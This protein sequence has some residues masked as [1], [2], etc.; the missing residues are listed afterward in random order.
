DLACTLSFE[1]AV[2]LCDAALRRTTHPVDAVP[3]TVLSRQDLLHELASVAHSYGVVK[4]REVI[5]F[6]DPL[7][8][9]P[10]ES[11]SRVSMHRAGIP[12]PQLQVALRGRSGTIWHV[13]FYWPEHGLIGE[14]DGTWKYT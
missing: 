4:A 12:E 3:K 2:P 14:F 13:D 1:R 11:V 7:A 10:G 6:A 9:R 8:D 5:H